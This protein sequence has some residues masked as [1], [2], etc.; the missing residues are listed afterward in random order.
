M[1]L[2]RSKKSATQ[3]VEPD[4]V[5]QQQGEQLPVPLWNFRKDDPI[6]RDRW[7]AIHCRENDVFERA[8]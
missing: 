6:A 7:L 4:R 8:L 1:F 3:R 5:H 2:G